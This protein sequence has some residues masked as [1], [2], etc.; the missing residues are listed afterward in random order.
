VRISKKT[1]SNELQEIPLEIGK[2]ISNGKT[3]LI[4]QSISSGP[5]MLLVTVGECSL[6]EA[7]GFLDISSSFEPRKKSRFLLSIKTGWFIG[8]PIIGVL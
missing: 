2:K 4:F 8:I 6:G 3:H 1:P 7:P 5:G